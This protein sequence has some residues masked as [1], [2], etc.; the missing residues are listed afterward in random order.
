MDVTEQRD[1]YEMRFIKCG[2]RYGKPGLRALRIVSNAVLVTF[3]LSLPTRG[4]QD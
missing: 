3:S 4:S 1:L 2:K